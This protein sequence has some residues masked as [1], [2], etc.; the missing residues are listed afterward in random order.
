MSKYRKIIEKEYYPLSADEPTIGL[1]MMVKNEHQRLHVSLDSVVDEETGEKFVDAIIIYDTGSEDDTM[2]IVKAFSE[3]HKI[4]LYMIQGEFEN[5]AVSRN[6]SLDYADTVN[7]H[8]LLL[9]D[10]NDELRG[11]KY[12]RS[13]ARQM[14]EAK[15]N[16]YLVVQLWKS[17]HYDRYYNTRFVKARSGW[18]YEGVVHEYMRDTL[19]K[20]NEPRF[21]VLSVDDRVILYQDRTADDDKSKKRF[22]RDR[23]LLLEEVRKNPEDSRSMF[24]LAQTCMCLHRNWESLYY[25]KK[26][27]DLGGFQEERYHAYLRSGIASLNLR[28]PWPVVMGWFT[29]SFQHSPRI[30]SLLKLGCF[31]EAT[32]NLPLAWAFFH[33]SCKVPFP[34]KDILFVDNV[35]YDYDCWHYLSSVAYRVNKFEEGRNASLKAIEHGIKPE[36][37]KMI[38]RNYEGKPKKD[39]KLPIEF[40]YSDHLVPENIPLEERLKKYEENKKD[41]TNVFWIGFEYLKRQDFRKALQFFRIRASLSDHGNKEQL[42]KTYLWLG[43]CCAK[44]NFSWTDIQGWFM[45]AF[46]HSPRAEP[47]LKLATYYINEK[48]WF[49]AYAFAKLACELPEPTKANN[50]D[51]DKKAYDYF[52][53]HYLGSICIQIGSHKEGKEA[54]ERAMRSAHKVGNDEMN[55]EYYNKDHKDKEETRQE[56]VHRTM[57]ELRIQNPSLSEKELKHKA[58]KKWKKKRKK[59]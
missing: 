50:I 11:G 46:E 33:T 40:R 20:S 15:N 32:G 18:R 48:C 12:L 28:H 31:Y 57:D 25:Q 3:K 17:Q 30:E 26:R 49:L 27:L 54:C 44:L 5:F 37:N 47:L 8:Y 41:E 9:L 55:L 13:Y 39:G 35:A 56:F 45:K 23:T 7:V 42:F 6:V 22:S 1:L 36:E 52:R 53:W 21:P 2:D 14:L 43:E 4:N 38:L 10:C 16:A 29:L 24:Y 34:K 19:S 58:V 59:N 51:Y